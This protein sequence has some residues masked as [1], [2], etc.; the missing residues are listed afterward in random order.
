MGRSPHSLVRQ[1][2][3]R[4]RLLAPS[5]GGTRLATLGS[6]NAASRGK[7]PEAR[8]MEEQRYGQAKKPFVE[9]VAGWS[10][11]HHIIAVVGW[12]VLV[13]LALTV[14]Q[15]LGQ[16]NISSYDPG[17]AGQAERVMDRPVVKQPPAE[18]FSCK[19]ARGPLLR[20]R[21]GP[22][23]GRVRGRHRAPKL[24]G[25]ATSIRSPLTSAGMTSGDSAL[26]TFQIPAKAD[27]NTAVVPDLNAVAS[28]AARHPGLKVE[29]A[30]DASLDRA[31]G[32]TSGQDFHKA[33]LTS[34]PVTLILL[35]MV[36]GALI[37]A[38]IPLLLAGT[39]VIAAISLL[40]IPGHWLPVERHHVGDRA[41]RRHGGRRRLLAVLPAPGAG[42]AGAGRTPRA[43]LQIAAAHVGPGHRGVRGDRDDLAGRAVPRRHRDVRRDGDRH[44]DGGRVAVLGSLTV[45]AGA[46]VAARPRDRPRPDPVPGSGRRPPGESGCGHA[47][48]RRVVRRPLAWGG[49]PLAVLAALAAPL[50]GMRL[51]DA[52]I[53]D[54]PNSVPV[55]RNLLD[56]QRAFPGG[57]TP[58]RWS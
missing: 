55:V 49:L 46:A 28:V 37:A 40:A 31:I 14:G 38:G 4:N 20:Q 19:R 9:R 36:F 34:I 1:T 39:A 27:A 23:A 24:P 21:S 7:S 15:R 10:A 22:A 13:A 35:L 25:S 29:E 6:M 26:V 44:H 5:P 41:A 30:G 3:P 57:P 45:P 54:L 56:I 18:T 50:L 51:Q 43:A 58:A 8:P 17:Q 32:N 47:L 16:G 33:E 11:R 53:H 2:P 52:G 42:G 12:L 48:V